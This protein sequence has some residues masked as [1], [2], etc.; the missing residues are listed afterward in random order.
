MILMKL[1]RKKFL[2]IGCSTIK[3]NA[4]LFRLL[5]ARY[6]VQERHEVHLLLED[7]PVNRDW[8]AK[9]IPGVQTH[10]L[11][12][13]PLLELVIERRRLIKQIKPDIVHIL[14]IGVQNVL[15]MPI[16]SKPSS[17]V[18][19]PDLDELMSAKASSLARRLLNRYLEEQALRISQTVIC[20]SQFL[21]EHLSHRHGRD[22]NQFLEL[23]YAYDPE[24][25]ATCQLLA[26]NIR[27]NYKPRKII[28]YMGTLCKEYQSN[29]VL[30]LAE[31]MQKYRKELV[32]LIIGDGSMF[33][34]NKKWVLHRKM[35]DFVCFLGYI[36]TDDLAS[37]LKAADVLLFPIQDNIQNKAR[38]P[39]KTFQ[40]IAAN[41]PI[42]TNKV[43][44]VERALGSDAYY[45]DFNS[46]E[47]F[48]KAV[49]AALADSHNYTNSRLLNLHTWKKR[50]INYQEW[51]SKVGVI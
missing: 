1:N 8:V 42:V 51:L 28:V 26:E 17:P 49:I 9:K 2:F 36:Y 14:G 19:I 45:Y 3:K 5:L 43:G 47:S 37:Y 50:T 27:S 11:S 15:T 48:K 41:R 10:Y 21:V 34:S 7:D 24:S 29:Q 46:I 30:E 13:K 33:K 20:A 22:R 40:Y 12:V 39:N 25:F 38:C 6:L 18:Y 4:A 32:F 23:P 16:L 44:E 35:E 31:N